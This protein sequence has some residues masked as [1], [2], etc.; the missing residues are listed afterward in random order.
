MAQTK[1]LVTH[2]GSAS[3][4]G[5]E[6]L[7]VKRPGADEP[8]QLARDA[9]SLIDLRLS[10]HVEDVSLDSDVAPPVKRTRAE[11]SARDGGGRQRQATPH[12]DAAKPKKTTKKKVAKK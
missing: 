11:R 6:P 3:S 1:T 7:W 12:R 8:S 2:G 4:E 5:F 9:Q 10:G